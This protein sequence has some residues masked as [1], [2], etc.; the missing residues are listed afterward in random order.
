MLIDDLHPTTHHS[1][2]MKRR[3]FIKKATGTALGFGVGYATVRTSA[4]GIH[5][6]P[7]SGMQCD[8]HIGDCVVS[9][10][11]PNFVVAFCSGLCSYANLSN[12]E[13]IVQCRMDT[14]EVRAI[15]CNVTEPT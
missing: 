4:W 5:L 3:S 15:H 6:T 2:P 12:L 9:Q 11:G 7:H 13:A 14:P 8:I 1:P 10:S